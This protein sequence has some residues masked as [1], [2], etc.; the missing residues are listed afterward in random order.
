M[1][2]AFAEDWAKEQGFRKAYAEAT[3]EEAKREVREAHKAFEATLEEKGE[4]YTRYFW[5]YDEAQK[6]GNACI[7]FNECIWDD[8]IPQM[9][10]DLRTFGIK[11][12]TLSSTYSS[13]VKTAWIF[14]Q[15]GCLLE[16]LEEINGR[17]DDFKTGEREKV[18]SFKF[19][20]K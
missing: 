12:F 5:E 10:E 8:Q 2:N 1:K 7:D 15:N 13:I 17:F 19:K 3:T 18:P 16:G 11:E 4:A 14:Q 20:I 9:V 6:R